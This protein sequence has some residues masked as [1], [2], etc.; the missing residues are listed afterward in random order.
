MTNKISTNSLYSLS[1]Q[2]RLDGFSFFIQNIQSQEVISFKNIFF[3]GNISIQNLS[4]HIEQGFNDCEDLQKSFKEVTV[5]YSNN[6][7]SVVPQALFEESKAVDYLKFNTK[8]LN[9]DFVAHDR[10]EQHDLIN[11][12]VPYTNVNNYFFENFGSFTYYHSTTLFIKQLFKISQGS[13]HPEAL[14]IT[15]PSHFY[16]GII[17]SKKILLI[18]FF[19]IKTPE[20]FIYYLLFCFEQLAINPDDI[21][22][23]LSGSINEGDAFYEKAYTYI[24]NIQILESPHTVLPKEHYLLASLI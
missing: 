16:L 15:S 9:T 12:Y 18:N 8:I 13:S 1:I 17:Q 14:V 23:K 20:D 22:L 2:V 3:N 4:N 10:I 6:L 11:V 24:R 19:D 21:L 5:V 7:F